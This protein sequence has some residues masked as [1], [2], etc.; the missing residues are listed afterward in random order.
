MQQLIRK[1]LAD[2]IIEP[3]SG[4]WAS[5]VVLVKK[6]DGS[7]CFCVDFRKL[8][9][10]TQ[11]DAQPLPRIDETLE[12]LSGSCCFSSFDLAS[13]YW[14]VPMDEADKPKTA[15]TT[16]FG[17]YQFN[18]MPFGL[19]NAPDTFQSLMTRVLAGLHWSV[20][21]VYLDDIIVFSPTIEEHFDRLEKVFQ[22]LRQAKLK[23]KPRKCLFFS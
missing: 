14:Q 18:V 15:F 8:N 7:A 12:F 23:V 19:C 9:A 3:S 5:P 10:V 6:K 16:P 11:K 1:M 21:L 20:A 22:A 4:L 17:L 13:G 2:N